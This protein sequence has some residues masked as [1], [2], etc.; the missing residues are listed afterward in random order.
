MFTLV[1]ILN[2]FINHFVSLSLYIFKIY[3]LQVLKEKKL[4]SGV[5]YFDYGKKCISVNQRY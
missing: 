4:A 3:R 5:H 1:I 2:P